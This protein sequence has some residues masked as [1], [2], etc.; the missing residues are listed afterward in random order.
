MQKQTEQLKKKAAEIADFKN[1]LSVLQWDQ[2]VNMPAQGASSR[3]QIIS[4]LSSHLH[5]LQTSNELEELLNEVASKNPDDFKTR[6]NAELMLERMQKTKKFSEEFV[7]RMNKTTSEAFLKWKKA[8]EENDFAQFAPH[9]EKIVDLNLESAEIIGYEEHPYDALLDG[10]DKGLTIKKTDQVFEQIRE[11]IINLVNELRESPQPDRSFLQQKFDLKKQM[12]LC[13][14]IVSDLGYDFNAGRLDLA[15]HPFSTSF[16]PGDNR[17]TTRLEEGDIMDGIL[18]S[19]HETGHALYDQN[20]DASQYGLPGGEPAS[21]SINESQSRLYENHIGRSF[22]F[23]S[24]FHEKLAHYFPDAFKNITPEQIYRAVNITEPSFVRTAADELTY[25][26]HIII[27]YEL[28]REM[29]EKSLKPADVKDAWNE[30][31]NKYLGIKVPDD[32]QGVLQDVHWSHGAFG[33]FPTYSLGSLYSAQFYAEAE[34]QISGL[35]GKLEQKQFTPLLNWLRENIH[36]HGKLYNSGDL[37]KKVTGEEL[38][39]QHFLNYAR[40][41]FKWVYENA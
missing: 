35:T 27:R 14:E 21:M 20:L 33:Y 34:K 23:I 4:T 7:S 11:P 28:E 9:L 32:R 6:R 19:I 26:L 40:E 37:A 41:K 38:N 36:Q 12:D 2:E 8:K 29:I 22:A 31:Y 15:P 16:G 25:H 5:R 30:K 3:S 18:S 1:A 10:F 24:A 17:I 39:P 13:K